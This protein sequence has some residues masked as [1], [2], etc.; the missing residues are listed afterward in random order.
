MLIENLLRIKKQTGA[1]D[2]FV[3]TFLQIIFFLLVCPNSVVSQ[4]QPSNS[5]ALIVV[6]FDP[7]KERGWEPSIPRSAWTKQQQQQSCPFNTGLNGILGLDAHF[8]TWSRY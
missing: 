2:G 7:T 6:R 3:R 8:D 4:L 1:F 5:R